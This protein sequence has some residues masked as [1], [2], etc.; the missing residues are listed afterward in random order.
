VKQRQQ[1]QATRCS[2]LALGAS[3]G[4]HLLCLAYV[5]GK[6]YGDTL[7]RICLGG[8][9]FGMRLSGGP[10]GML[11]GPVV[12]GQPRAGRCAGAGREV[13]RW[14]GMRGW[15]GGVVTLFGAIVDKVQT[16][17]A[18]RFACFRWCGLQVSTL[19][20]QRC[21]AQRQTLRV[22]GLP[23]KRRF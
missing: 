21:L 1:L 19:R 17:A 12:P 10:L 11:V 5:F 6:L 22:L 13:W 18:S 20:R 16:G 14:V 15:C 23:G 3:G 8:C 7:C 2:L 9:V 4:L